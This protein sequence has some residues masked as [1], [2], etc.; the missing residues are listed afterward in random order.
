M[1]VYA[2]HLRLTAVS[3]VPRKVSKRFRFHSGPG[4]DVY[5]LAATS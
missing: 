3:E 4:D 1:P 5:V 2:R